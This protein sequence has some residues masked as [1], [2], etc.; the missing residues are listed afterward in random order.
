[1]GRLRIAQF[2]V[3]RATKDS[4]GSYSF[5]DASGPDESGATNE[6]RRD[7]VYVCVVAKQSIRRAIDLAG[8]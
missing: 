3:S 4:D 8:Q 6:K 1:M 2:F 7:P 5:F